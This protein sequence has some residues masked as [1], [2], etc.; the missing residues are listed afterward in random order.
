MIKLLDCIGEVV[1]VENTGIY[2]VGV[3]LPDSDRDDTIDFY[4]W[5]L[6]IDETRLMEIR[7]G[8]V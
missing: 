8:I 5:E 4:D 7:H 1:S 6:A 2:D 3:Y